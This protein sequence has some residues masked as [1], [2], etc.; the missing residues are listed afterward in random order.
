MTNKKRIPALVLAFLFVFVVLSCLFFIAVAS[1][2]DCCGE[3]C[4]ICAQIINVE[5]NLQNFIF[6]VNFVFH[7]AVLIC[8]A[9]VLIFTLKARKINTLVSLKVKLSD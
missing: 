7:A 9:A 4:E 6:S 8:L 3:N 2:H 1:C 5:H